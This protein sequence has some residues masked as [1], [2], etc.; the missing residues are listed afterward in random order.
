MALMTLV[1]DRPVSLS[2]SGLVK[3][4]ERKRPAP[5]DHEDSAPPLKKQATSINGN[6]KA[7]IDAEMPWK[8]ELEVRRESLRSSG[9]CRFLSSSSRSSVYQIV[10]RLSSY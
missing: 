1:G 7:H 6:A 2:S 4:E 3:M 8:D 9:C 5:H 10:Y